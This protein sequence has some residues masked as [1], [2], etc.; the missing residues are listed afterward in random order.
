MILASEFGWKVAEYGNGEVR[1]H[2]LLFV[3][4]IAALLFGGWSK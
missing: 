4:V 3:L 1:L 2:G